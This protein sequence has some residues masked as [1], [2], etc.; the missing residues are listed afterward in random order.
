MSFN[1]FETES[2][3]YNTRLLMPFLANFVFLYGKF[4]YF[5]FFVLLIFVLIIITTYWLLHQDL[6][7]N[8]FQLISICT[9]SFIMYQFQLPGYPDVLLHIL[10][11]ASI[12][13]QFSNNSKIALLVLS[14]LTHESSLFITSILSIFILDKKSLVKFYGIFVIYLLFWVSGYGFDLSAALA[15]HRYDNINSLQWVLQNPL[16]EVLGI[17]F[18]YKLLWLFIIF[19]FL[20]LIKVNQKKKALL[21]SLLVLSSIFMTL[22]AVDT[23]RLVGWSFIGLLLS[24]QTIHRMTLKGW[25]KKILNSI[26]IV[27]LMIPSIHYSLNVE[28]KWSKGLYVLYKVLA[29]HMI[30]AY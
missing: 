30:R 6:G 9:S 27:N 10:L 11:L 7:I 25:R 18:S 28:P 26:Y 23:S 15:S 3:W 16:R 22:L 17:F 14:L 8:T 13:F 20:Y 29:E 4:F 24:V 21:I 2:G 12:A 19:S 5:I 1:P